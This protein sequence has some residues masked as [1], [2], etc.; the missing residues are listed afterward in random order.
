MDSTNIEFYKNNGKTEIMVV[1]QYCLRFAHVF[2]NVEGIF[3]R[4]VKMAS[5]IGTMLLQYS[6]LYGTIPNIIDKSPSKLAKNYIF[7]CK[8]CYCITIYILFKGKNFVSQVVS[9]LNYRTG[10]SNSSENRTNKY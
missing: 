7:L 9:I 5:N 1:Q 4:M 8:I 6:M 10:D 3:A 2:I